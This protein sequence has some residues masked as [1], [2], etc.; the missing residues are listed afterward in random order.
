MLKVLKPTPLTDAM[1]MGAA[2]PEAD[3]PAYSAGTTYALDAP[4]IY[5][6]K[7][8]QS[9]AGANTGH[10]PDEVASTWWNDLGPTNQW[11]PFDTKVSTACTLTTS[12]GTPTLWFRL[13]PGVC[14][15]VFVQGLVGV[16]S[17]RVQMFNAAVLVYDQVRT[18][19]ATFIA[20]A[21]DYYFAPFDVLSDLSFEELPPFYN[22]EVLITLTPAALGDTIKVAGIALGQ[23]IALAETRMGLGVDFKDYSIKE[24][25][26]IGA[27]KIVT[28]IEGDYSTKPRYLLEVPKAYWRRVHGVIVSLRAT[29]CAWICGADPDLTPLNTFGFVSEFSELYEVRGFVYA[30]LAIESM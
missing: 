29:P 18:L 19:D 25:K 13:R 27:E 30:T 23:L 8:Y 6:H 21:W 11:A 1:F 12:V 7:R 16:A 5:K 20:D 22:A 26:A 2:V 15:G 4:V 9:L 10:A 28:L 14:S 17:V 24:V 3:H